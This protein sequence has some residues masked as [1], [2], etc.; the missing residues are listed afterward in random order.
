MRNRARWTDYQEATDEMFRKTST[1]AHPWHVIPS[2]DKR[3]SRLTV[4][5]TVVRTLSK[6]VEM[7]LPD[8]DP[9]FEQ[10]LRETLGVK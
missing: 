7:T 3:H 1:V 5:E 8:L 2:N 9:E 6:G 10:K 4:I